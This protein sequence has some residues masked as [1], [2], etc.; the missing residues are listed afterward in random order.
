VKRRQE[1]AEADQ[2]IMVAQLASKLMRQV[3]C[4]N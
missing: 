4:L 1:R 2:N 3:A